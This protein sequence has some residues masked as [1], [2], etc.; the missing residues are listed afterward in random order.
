MS[1]FGTVKTTRGAPLSTGMTDEPI[2]VRAGNNNIAVRVHLLPSGEYTIDVVDSFG[3]RVGYLEEP[4][5]DR[6]GRRVLKGKLQ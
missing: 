3:E 5:A 1:Y 4:K 2:E 6:K